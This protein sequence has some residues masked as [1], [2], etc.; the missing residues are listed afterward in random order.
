M[1]V[2]AVG[3]TVSFEKGS[4]VPVVLCGGSGTRLWPLSRSLYPK[5]LVA[6]QEEQT[7]LQST[8]ARVAGQ[9]FG[10]PLIVANEEHRFLIADQLEAVGSEPLAILL[11][12]QGRNTA[13]AIALAARFL[14][15]RDPD[16]LMLVMPSD[17]LIGNPALFKQSVQSGAIAARNGA[18]VTF[19]AEARSPE[20]GYGYIE[21]GGTDE[22]APGVL[23]VARFVEK[24][25]ADTAERYVES[26]HHYWNCGIFLFRADTYLRELE[27]QEPDVAAAV[28]AAMES[29]S[30]DGPF[31]RPSAAAFAESP[32]ISIDYAV[33]ERTDA[34]RVV[35][36]DMGWSDVGSWNSLWEIAPKDSNGNALT[37]DVLPIDT[38]GSL[39]RSDGSFTVATVGV[40]DL[41]V[42]ATRDAVLI[43]PRGRAQDTRLVVEELKASGHES[44]MLHPRV[45]RPWGTYETM[46]SGPRFQT[47]R[48]V[49]K[50]GA[51][52]SLQKHHHRSEHWIV[53][54]GTAEV[55]VG[56]KVF[57]LQE[58]Q[59]TYIP[60][61]EV[62]RLAN[63]GRVPLH[64]IEV[65][66]GTYLGEDDIVRLEDTYGRR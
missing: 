18:L 45:H 43:L 22:G 55:T 50:P 17:H 62:H 39:I 35:P 60:A 59:S 46:D 20:T 3:S 13:P 51:K 47:K 44:I 48:I 29:V 56:E 40:K 27:R 10:A 4:I 65:Q 7:L 19:G 41:I 15:E 5:Q 8:V 54:S 21:A 63:P 49:V 11:E 38:E 26:G 66:C 23:K 34:A 16:A 28:G 9:G 1:S 24:P 53:V 64:L 33:M 42:V 52:L 14:I 36:V 61:G 2:S 37:G 32:S 25:D 58:N 6:L 57:L 31:V 30:L 12:P